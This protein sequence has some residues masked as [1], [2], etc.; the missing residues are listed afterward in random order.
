MEI[1][2]HWQKSSFSGAEGP[3][4]LEIAGVPD[5]LLMRES[6]VPGTVLAASRAEFAGLVAAVKAGEFDPLNVPGKR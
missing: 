3:N 5:R 6:D 4:C 2:V 1:P